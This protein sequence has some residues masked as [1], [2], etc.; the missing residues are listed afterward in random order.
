[1]RMRRHSPGLALTLLTA[2]GIIGFV[3]RILMNV[4]VEPLK[5]EFGL[6]DK[7]IGLLTGL[8]FALVNVVLG[9]AVARVAERRRRL[10]L[11]AIGTVLW[12]IAT[13]ACGA[14]SNFTQ[15]AL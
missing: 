6:S 11:V 14:V 8:A 9:L 2:I 7:A 4:M 5:A 3:D 12:S 10:T 1:M 15:L 13:A